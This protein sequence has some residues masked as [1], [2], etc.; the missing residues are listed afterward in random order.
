LFKQINIFFQLDRWSKKKFLIIIIIIYEAQK[1]YSDLS[2]YQFS[3]NVELNI[4]ED[5]LICL[6]FLHDKLT[7]DYF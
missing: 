1:I 3:C 5:V 7:H 2:Q 4:I 6:Q